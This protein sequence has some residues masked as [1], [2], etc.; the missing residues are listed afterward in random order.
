MPNKY[1]G[2]PGIVGSNFNAPPPSATLP[3][4]KPGTKGE[5]TPD[6]KFMPMTEEAKKGL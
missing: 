4:P 6:P 1:Y 3:T 5:R 2:T